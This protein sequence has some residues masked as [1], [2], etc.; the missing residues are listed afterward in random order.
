MNI[1]LISLIVSSSI[2]IVAFSFILYLRKMTITAASLLEQADL[3]KLLLAKRLEQ[4]IG[5]KDSTKIEQSEGFVRFLSESRDSAFLY[6]ENVQNAIAELVTYEK[7]IVIDPKMQNAIEAYSN[8]K[9]FLPN[10]G[11]VNKEKK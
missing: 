1:E 7:N 8:L 3:D 11:T 10:E 5:S 6:I 2:N 9:K 4:E